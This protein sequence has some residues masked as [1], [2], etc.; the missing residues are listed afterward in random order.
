MKLRAVIDRYLLPGFAFKAVVIGGGYA[1]GRELVEFFLPAG[2]IGGLWS[3]LLA[4]A[5]WSLVCALTFRLAYAL[6]ATD[7]N[8]FFRP[9]LGRFE[10]AFELI[11]FAFLI[12]VLSVFGSAAGAIGAAVLGLPSLAGTLAL[13]AAVLL[14]CGAGQGAAEAV[15]KYVSVLLYTVY[16]LFL[17][18]ALW[19]FAPAIAAG[20]ALDVPA[21]GWVAGGVTYASYNVIGA[22]LILPV[23]RHL[24]SGREAVVAGLLAGPLAILPGIAFFVALVGFYPAILDEPL[25]SDRVLRAMQLPLFHYLFQAMV[26]FALVE[27]SVGFVQAFNARIDAYNARRGRATSRALRFLVP[28]ALTTGS[29]FL[30]SGVGLVALIA[31]GYRWMAYATLLVFVVPLF[32]IG[33]ARLWRGEMG[34]GAREV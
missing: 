9:L 13:V 12:L 1:T 4:M 27:C 15:F 6:G 7:Y 23:L 24:R 21:R 33:V 8:S 25:P 22:V 11:Y 14:V 18:L 2:P 29:I 30:A 20:F 16:A 19:L 34:A 26:F 5:I 28:A 10:L 32:T 31:H 3:M 17:V